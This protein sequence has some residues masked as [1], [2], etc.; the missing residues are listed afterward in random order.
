MKRT[1][2]I[3]IMMNLKTIFSMAFKIV[4]ISSRE[5]KLSYKSESWFEMGKIEWGLGWDFTIRS[6]AY[7]KRANSM[8][9]NQW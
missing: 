7:N 8:W 2:F 1:I 5:I 3:L 6:H 4:S 9:Q